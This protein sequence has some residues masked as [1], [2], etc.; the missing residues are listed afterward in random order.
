MS[1]DS[2]HEEVRKL[3]KK[4]FFIKLEKNVLVCLFEERLNK[5]Y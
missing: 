4:V 5:F 2:L 3:I 1:V